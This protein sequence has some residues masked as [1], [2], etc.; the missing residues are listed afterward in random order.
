M[1]LIRRGGLT[2]VAHRV[3]RSAIDANFVVYVRTSGSPADADIAD[4]VAAPQLLAYED[5]ET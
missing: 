1:E 2:Q 4:R 3:D 5:I